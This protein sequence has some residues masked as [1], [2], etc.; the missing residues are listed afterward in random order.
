MRADGLRKGVSKRI[1][2][3]STVGALPYGQTGMSSKIE[4][5]SALASSLREL[6]PS[7]ANT[8]G[9]GNRRCGG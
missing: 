7:F 4:A 2:D 5:R 8:F 9:G 1:R 6:I 3:Q